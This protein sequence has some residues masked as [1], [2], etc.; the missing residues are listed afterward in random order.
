[1]LLAAPSVGAQVSVSA[2]IDSTALLIGEQT[3]IH[4]EATQNAGQT[5][6]FP[7][8]GD[9]IVTGV[10]VLNVGKPDTVRL[11]ADRISVRQDVLVTSFDSALYYMP[12]FRFV[13]GADTLLT[14]PLALKVTT[15]DV[16]T[17]SKEY[18][19][20]K[21]VKSAPFVWQ[22][23]FLELLIA[24][25]LLN[26]IVWGIYA[27]RRWKYRKD[28]PLEVIG[29][30]PELPPLEAA[31]Q[32]LDKLKEQKLWQ[33]GLEKEYYTALTDILR[34]YLHRRFGI[35]AMELT[36]SEIL[37][38]VRRVD[39]DKEL[40]GELRQVLE[41]AD[42][43]KFAKLRPT[44]DDNE[45]SLTYAYDIVNRTPELVAEPAEA[46]EEEKKEEINIQKES[47]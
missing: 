12:P 32:A 13:A 24:L 16:D 21:P 17:E 19:D 5:V 22:D 40:I 31:I 34:V 9:T 30:E 8:L 1:M 20:I 46:D 35:N 43:V 38:A 42:F 26:A 44:G 11:S 14:D 18:F 29:M 28:H 39:I 7:L 23:Y 37:D 25:I 41:T 2:S 15:Y 45:A 27:Y 6:Q 10:E 36:S 33:H 4:L 47:K 3:L